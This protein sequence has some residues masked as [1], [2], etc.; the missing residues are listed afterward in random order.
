MTINSVKLAMILDWV[1]ARQ[2]GVPVV[3]LAVIT[4]DTIVDSIRVVSGATDRRFTIDIAT[5]TH[6]C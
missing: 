4:E 2:S 3:A 6:N 5:K 1:G